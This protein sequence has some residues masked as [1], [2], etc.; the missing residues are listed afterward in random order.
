VHRSPDE[1]GLPSSQGAVLL[2]CRQVPPLQLSSVHGL[3]S[4]QSIG[5]PRHVP[6]THASPVVQASPSL[7]GPFVETDAVSL[8]A[9]ESAVSAVTLAVFVIGPA[10]LDVTTITTVAFAP[11]T[12]SPSV[13]TTVVPPLQLPWLGVTDTND[14]ELGSGSRSTMLRATFAPRLSTFRS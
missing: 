2:V 7:Q 10:V 9:F 4:L 1:H 6:P 5:A 12:T 3:V 14:T 8:A 11:G 13:Q